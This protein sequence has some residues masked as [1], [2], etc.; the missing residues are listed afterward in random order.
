[1]RWLV[2]CNVIV[3]DVFFIVVR[4]CCGLFDMDS[5]CCGFCYNLIVIV[6]WGFFYEVVIY[7]GVVGV[8]LID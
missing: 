5:E 3:K 6:K 1:M 7:L 2:I 8:F 4:C